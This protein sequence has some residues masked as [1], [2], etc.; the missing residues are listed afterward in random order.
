M[1]G[2]EENSIITCNFDKSERKTFSCLLCFVC[3]CSMFF[4]RPR[5]PTPPIPES[6]ATSLLNLAFEHQKTFS[7][8]EYSELGRNCNPGERFIWASRWTI[9]FFSS[10]CQDKEKATTKSA[11]RLTCK[12]CFVCHSASIRR[13]Y[14]RKLLI[15]PAFT[16]VYGIL[17][18]FIAFSLCNSHGEGRGEKNKQLNGLL[19]II[20]LFCLLDCV[21][22]K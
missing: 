6:R 17:F 9:S 20:L 19:A 7:I 3:F 4:F 13:I 8:V 2:N 22:W 14:L 16:C 11:F 1:E 21:H 12:L 18:S 10:G 5:N 15:K